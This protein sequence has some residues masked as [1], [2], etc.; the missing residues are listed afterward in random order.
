II[1]LEAGGELI[2]QARLHPDQGIL[3]AREQFEFGNLLAVW[4]EAVQ[5]G[6]VRSSGLGKP[7][8]HQSCRS[9]HPM[10]IADDP[11]CE[12]SRARRASL[13]PTGEQSTTHGSSR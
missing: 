2:D 9:W 5:I 13:L 7:S 4:G 1:R 8:R 6:Q 12:Y 10:R 11:R 3:I